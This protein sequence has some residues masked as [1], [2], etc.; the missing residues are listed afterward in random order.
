MSLAFQTPRNPDAVR[1]LLKYAT[2]EG[3]PCAE[4]RRAVRAVMRWVEDREQEMK[5]REYGCV[6]LLKEAAILVG[7]ARRVG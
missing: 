7:Q 1:D 4:R 3:T 5:D 2:Q 6:A